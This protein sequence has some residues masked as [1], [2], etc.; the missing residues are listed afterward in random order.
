MSIPDFS[1]ELS[2]KLDLREIYLH[3]NL[4]RFDFNQRISLIFGYF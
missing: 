2:L 1:I 3:I 4:S